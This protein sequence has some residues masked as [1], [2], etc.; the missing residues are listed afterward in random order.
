MGRRHIT[1][2]GGILAVSRVPAISQPYLARN[3]TRIQPPFLALPHVFPYDGSRHSTPGVEITM[4]GLLG[5]EARS[6]DLPL[7]GIK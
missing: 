7:H 3:Q 6:P 2:R 1:G 4:L 5:A